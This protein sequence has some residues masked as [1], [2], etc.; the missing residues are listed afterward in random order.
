MTT[1]T[2]TATI[3]CAKTKTE[4]SP[5]AHILFQ[6]AEF[7]VG[8]ISYDQFNPNDYRQVR[9]LNKLFGKEFLEDLEGTKVRIIVAA[10]ESN[11]MCVA[12]LA[13]G[14]PT[15]NEFLLRNGDGTSLTYEEATLKLQAK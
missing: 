7:C 1:F 12:P 8:G 14:H 4:T 9:Q 2:T 13:I 11:P 10:S 3:T 5:K 6:T 15:A